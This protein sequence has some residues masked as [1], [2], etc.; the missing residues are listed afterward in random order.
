MFPSKKHIL[1]TKMWNFFLYIYLYQKDKGENVPKMSA[2]APR[3]WKEE[4]VR[5]IQ[6]TANY[7]A[8]SMNAVM[9]DR[10][11]SDD[12]RDSHHEERSGE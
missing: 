4:Q 6:K 1:N 3:G 5:R 7:T 9:F 11:Y 2:N 10:R 12:G 8:L